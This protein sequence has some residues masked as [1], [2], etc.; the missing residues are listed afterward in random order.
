[1]E[2]HEHDIK[3]F[4]FGDLFIKWVKILYK[5][6]T[7]SIINNGWV[8]E[9]FKIS[10]GIRQG[11][12]I[13]ALL[14]ILCGEIMAENIRNNKNINGITIGRDKEIKLTQMADD[15]TIFLR[16]EHDI[17]ILIA[18]L[19]RFTEV[20]G[21]TL[22]T[23]KTKGL[24][25]GRHRRTRNKIHDINFS[26]TAIKSLGVYFGTSKQE[27]LQLNWNKLI[28]DIQNLLN[29]WKRRKLTVFGKI[30]VLKSLVM[31]KC[32]YLLQCMAVPDQILNKIESLLFKLLWND[33]NDKIKRKQLMQK[34]EYGGLKMVDIKV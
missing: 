4:G 20:S 8:S 1:M 19:K 26:A 5:N 17:P 21:L 12:P 2:F 7:N 13:S 3:K 22:N 14:Y 33:K 16:A 6:T 9:S 27:C 18:E 24:S 23:S 25:F 10:R 28:E 15:T 32:N 30:V 34:Y 11:C 31:S 29:S